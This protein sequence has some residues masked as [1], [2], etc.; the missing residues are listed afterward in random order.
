MANK[1]FPFGKYKGQ[2][3][4]EVASSG[5][6]RKYLD[7]FKSQPIRDDKYKEKNTEFVLEIERVLSSS[8]APVAPKKEKDLPI[9]SDVKRLDVIIQKLDTIL[10]LLSKKGVA[11]DE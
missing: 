8:V 4:E 3:I 7:W 1:V 5:D 9:V 11:F 6:G 10:D 2:S